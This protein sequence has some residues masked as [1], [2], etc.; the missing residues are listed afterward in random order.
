MDA[1]TGKKEQMGAKCSYVV[2]ELMVGSME[3][4]IVFGLVVSRAHPSFQL[5]PTNLG[6][7]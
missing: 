2:N 6:D 4:Q 1:D 3:G 5:A 7:I